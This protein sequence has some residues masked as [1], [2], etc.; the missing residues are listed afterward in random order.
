M[1]LMCI[2]F[3]VI[4]KNVVACSKFAL[5]AASSAESMI[6]PSY[7]VLSDYG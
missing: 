6:H 4:V 3:S 5:T 7:P 1:V 2:G